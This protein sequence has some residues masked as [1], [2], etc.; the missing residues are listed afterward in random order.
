M[1][2]SYQIFSHL[3]LIAAVRQEWVTR[4]SVI[5]WLAY[6]FFFWKIGDPFPILSPQRGLISIEQVGA[7][8]IIL[9]NKYNKQ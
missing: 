6:L 3:F 5:T 4:F 9:L 8:H 7:V 1:F 2:K